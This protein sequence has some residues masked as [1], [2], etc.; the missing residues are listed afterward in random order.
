MDLSKPKNDE[1]DFLLPM[2]PKPSPNKKKDEKQEQRR[3]VS[4]E[5]ERGEIHQ[6]GQQSEQRL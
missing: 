3:A 4:G 2:A 5:G 1:G 6:P